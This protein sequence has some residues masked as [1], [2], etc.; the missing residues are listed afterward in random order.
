MSPLRFWSFVSFVSCVILLGLLAPVEPVAADVQDYSP[1]SPIPHD[2][3]NGTVTAIAVIGSDVYVGGTFTETKDG[4]VSDLNLI[5]KFSNGTWEPMPNLGLEGQAVYRLAA[6]GNDLYVGGTFSKTK[7]GTVEGLNNIAKFSNGEWSALPNQGLN[8]DVTALS[9]VGDDLYVG[10]SFRKTYDN[11]VQDLLGIA[12]FTNGAWTAL[13]HK[14]L[15]GHVYAIRAFKGDVYVGGEFGSTGDNKFHTTNFAKLAEGKQ[16][17]AVPDGGLKSPVWAFEVM[18]GRLVIG[19]NFTTSAEGNTKGLNYIAFYDGNKYLPFA[20]NGLNFVV[21]GLKFVDGVLYVGGQFDATADKQVD[22]LNRIAKYANGKWSGMPNRGL[23]G[24][25]V[26]T[27][28]TRGGSLLI[29][30]SFSQTVDTMVQDIWR[31]AEFDLGANMTLK[32]SVRKGSTPTESIATLTVKN[33]GPNAAFQ[34]AVTDIVPEGY[35]PINFTTD[36]GTCNKKNNKVTCEYA[37]LGNNETATI[38][39][40]VQSNGANRVVNNCAVVTSATY[41]PNKDNKKACARIPPQ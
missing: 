24:D 17:E 8:S 21:R 10:G 27:L 28:T 41:D 38:Q 19:G 31:F 32:Q 33:L 13:P 35:T 37:T 26:L 30:G 36:K 40:T 7:D 20:N 12:K 25:T 9:A 18:Q 1:W 2:G 39:L 11:A 34:V 16:W 22:N 23:A 6:I 14:G 4:Q 3:L 15:A 5:A 29:G